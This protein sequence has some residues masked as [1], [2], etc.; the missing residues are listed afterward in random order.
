M[1]CVMQ[2]GHEYCMARLMRIFLS[3]MSQKLL[4]A[5][6][7][8]MSTKLWIAHET[9]AKTFIDKVSIQGC[10]DV[11]DFKGIIENVTF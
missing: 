6:G 11:A 5:F 8:R 4:I 10:S 7:R 2:A 1:I 3:E 9:P